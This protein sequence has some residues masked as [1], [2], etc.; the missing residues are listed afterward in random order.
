MTTKDLR[1]QLLERAAQPGLSIDD[2][3]R[4]VE[5]AKSLSEEDKNRVES[6]KLASEAENLRSTKWAEERR[7]YISILA[8][9]VSTIVLALTLVL[10][11]WQTHQKN[12]Q[13]QMERESKDF[14]QALTDASQ[15]D[16]IKARIGSAV[17]ARFLDSPDYAQDARNAALSMLQIIEEPAGFETLLQGVARHTTPSQYPDLATLD[18]VLKSHYYP[19][20]DY[21]ARA[22]DARA[23]GQPLPTLPLEVRA[24][25]GTGRLPSPEDL[26]PFLNASESNMALVGEA[27]APL[28]R[29]PDVPKP[30]K[31]KETMW[32]HNAFSGDFSQADLTGAELTVR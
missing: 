15:H 25:F 7:F 18:R 3:S 10:Q 28:L 16:A 27:I 24:A 21:V 2:Q 29:G 32:W 8:P 23:A 6:G 19:I 26:Q 30:L 5:I 20:Q 17:F 1:D 22:E 13:D 12:R 11:V 14:H 4:L 9:T 31:L